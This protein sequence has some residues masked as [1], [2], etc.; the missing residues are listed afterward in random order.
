MSEPTPAH[1]LVHSQWSFELA[2]ACQRFAGHTLDPEPEQFRLAIATFSRDLPE[3]T[4]AAERM[5]LRDRLRLATESAGHQFH[6]QFHRYFGRSCG[7]HISP[8]H[9][10]YSTDDGWEIDD[11]L[12]RWAADYLQAFE[13]THRWPGQVRAARH[14]RHHF[15]EPLNITQL[16][17]L[18][19]CGRG[20]LVRT[21]AATFGMSI[22]EYHTR[23]RIRAAFDQ[24]RD[25]GSNVGE[26]AFAVG[27]RS[28]KNFYRALRSHTGLTPSQVRQL[29][30]EERRAAR[31]EF[32]LELPRPRPGVSSARL[33]SGDAPLPSDADIVVGG[34]CGSV[35]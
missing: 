22:V 12:F 21:F 6:A 3:T 4:T 30:D 9:S 18:V 16:A 34:S 5:I 17:R 10:W 26:V 15:G 20:T 35:G 23:C 28:R 7:G 1:D 11:V 25:P 32:L 24:L 2:A 33:D 29:G 27:Y 13:K 14:L 8:R 31:I 19:A